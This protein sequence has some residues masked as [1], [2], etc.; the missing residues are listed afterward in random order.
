MSFSEP[1]VS[2]KPGVS[3]I[4]KCSFSNTLTNLV[5]DL[6]ECPISNP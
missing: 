6:E 2:D 5:T 1:F 4:L 3:T